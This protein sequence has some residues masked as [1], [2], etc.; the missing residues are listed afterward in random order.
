MLRT[1]RQRPEC[2]HRNQGLEEMAA[3]NR[4]IDLAAAEWAV[5]IDAGPLTAE[6][7]AEFDKWVAANERHRG[8]LLHW[9]AALVDA[10]RLAAL[11]G[12][13]RPFA[14][15]TPSVSG[16]ATKACASYGGTTNRRW[17][18]AA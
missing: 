12:H 4:E 13:Q 14:A 9:R 6:E 3:S 8:A 7:Q 11:A 16:A 17:F 2:H 18:I 15:D 10:Y 5:R 1:T